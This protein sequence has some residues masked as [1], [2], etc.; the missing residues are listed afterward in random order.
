M[1]LCDIKLAQILFKEIAF[2]R[3]LVKLQHEWLHYLK[4]H[5]ID[6]DDLSDT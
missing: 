3:H 5:V 6:A 1:W 2:V 4:I